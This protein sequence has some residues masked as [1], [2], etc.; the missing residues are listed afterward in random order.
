[1]HGDNYLSGSRIQASSTTPI[2]W[3]IK[4]ETT[5]TSMWQVF[6]L[7]TYKCSWRIKHPT[8]TVLSSWVC[9]GTADGPILFTKSH[10]VDFE[11]IANSRNMEFKVT[12][13][14]ST[15]KIEVLPG[16]FSH[17]VN[18]DIDDDSDTVTEDL[19]QISPVVEEVES[20]SSDVEDTDFDADSEEA[21][22]FF[23]AAQVQY[24]L[25]LKNPI[26]YN[27]Q[28]ITLH[29][30]NIKVI[31]LGFQFFAKGNKKWRQY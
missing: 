8:L 23:K 11:K 3:Y 13:V 24:N 5:S 1:M 16:V 31:P 26:E 29:N 12:P 9:E 17:E 15:F 22:D 10:R 21:I 27:K 19:V 30:T 7:P 14:G 28:C 6:G 2:G 25:Y 4:G 18:L 20:G